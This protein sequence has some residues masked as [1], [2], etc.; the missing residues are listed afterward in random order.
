LKDSRLPRYIESLGAGKQA[1]AVLSD[2]R[3]MDFKAEIAPVDS[4]II[5]LIKK[6]FVFWAVSLLGIIPLVLVTLN[7]TQ[8]QL[9][10]FLLSPTS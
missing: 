3:S 9:V 7:D 2:L 1:S 10:G 8:S 6:D 4:T 5:A